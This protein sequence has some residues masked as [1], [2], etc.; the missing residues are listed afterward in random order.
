MLKDIL[1]NQL[2]INKLPK[3][4]KVSTI[5]LSCKLDIQID[6]NEIASKLKLNKD[7]IMEIH[8]GKIDNTETNRTLS[9]KPI[10]IKRSFYNGITLK[11]IVMNKI[12]PVNV[13]LFINGSLQITGCQ[14]IEN[15]IDVI[16]KV[17]NRLKENKNYL[18][19]K[20]INLNVNKITDFKIA[21]INSDYNIGFKIDLQSLHK[22]L[23]A[24]IERIYNIVR[25]SCVNIKYY[26]GTKMISI[27]VFNKGSIIITGSTNF[28]QLIASYN[29]IDELLIKNYKEIV[30]NSYIYKEV[31]DEYMKII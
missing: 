24:E 6:C 13:K 7:D 31:I 28:Q 19:D 30:D 20:H 16:T 1:N 5:T 18:K 25:H 15:I 11:V 4:I 22:I 2:E 21:L 3:E 17:I 27:F 12:K 14:N 26:V 8:Y 10:K 9:D 23:P 29:Y